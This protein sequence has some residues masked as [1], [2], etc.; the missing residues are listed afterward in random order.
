[1]DQSGWRMTE[2]DCALDGNQPV[3]T[4]NLDRNTYG[5]NRILLQ[6]HP[7]AVINADKATYI[8]RAPESAPRSSP[9]TTLVSPMD[10]Q[11]GLLSD[12]ELLR[13]LDIQHVATA[14]TDISKSVA[15][16]PK[17]SILPAAVAGAGQPAAEPITSITIQTGVAQGDLKISGDQMWMLAGLGPIMDQPSIAL[18]TLVLTISSDVS[19]VGWEL[20]A[21]YL[22]RTKSQ[23]VIP[24]VPI[25][26]TSRIVVPVPEKYRLDP[27]APV[28]VSTAAAP[29]TASTSSTAK[30]PASAHP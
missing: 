4:I 12:I 9:L 8:V 30:T 21:S 29:A 17:P 3:C 10:F 13:G 25:D 20:D 28:D 26:E 27:S 23:P 15:L 14:S 11:V 7:D 16:P 24:V 6:D 18:K 1:M 2:I 19:K 22:L 5:V